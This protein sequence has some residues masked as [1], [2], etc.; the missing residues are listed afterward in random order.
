MYEDFDDSRFAALRA[1]RGLLDD[2]ARDDW[3]ELLAS[4]SELKRAFVTN[5]PMTREDARVVAKYL[6]EL[7]WMEG[8][9]GAATSSPWCSV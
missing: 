5:T 6:R 4:Y 7:G 8:A 1:L 3:N 2:D 9:I